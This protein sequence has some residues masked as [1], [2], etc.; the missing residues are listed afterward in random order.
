[1]RSAP[2]A[3]YPLA[4]YF[5]AIARSR[6]FWH[7][8]PFPWTSPS[9]TFTKTKS[10]PWPG[11]ASTAPFSSHNVW[12]SARQL[13]TSSLLSVERSCHTCKKPRVFP[14]QAH[15]ICLDKCSRKGLFGKPQV[16]WLKQKSKVAVDKSLQ[17]CIDLDSG[18]FGLAIETSIKSNYPG[19]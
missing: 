14:R 4:E 7:D 17:K 16:L 18:W 2:A 3:T 5:Q 11:D 9:C 1:M 6:Q 19:L 8:R 12:C 10:L 15:C 13:S